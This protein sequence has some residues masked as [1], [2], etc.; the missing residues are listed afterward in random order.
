[1]G[2]DDNGSTEVTVRSC[3]LRPRGAMHPLTFEFTE[4]EDGLLCVLEFNPVLM[5]D[6]HLTVILEALPRVLS[7][8]VKGLGPQDILTAVTVG[9]SSAGLAR[10]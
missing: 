9:Q 3:P 4:Q 1:M 2:G 10:A 5:A 7:G 6:E 8:L